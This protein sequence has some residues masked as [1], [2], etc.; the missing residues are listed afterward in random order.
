[1]TPC[2]K[3]GWGIVRRAFNKYL[4]G[5]RTKAPNSWQIQLIE[6]SYRAAQCKPNYIGHMEYAY[7]LVRYLE[8]LRREIR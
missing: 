5:Q 4:K 1:M 7:D 8:E 3:P 2:E 6:E